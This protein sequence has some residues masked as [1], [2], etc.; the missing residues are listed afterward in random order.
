MG[1]REAE[2]QTD[3]EQ[4]GCRREH[5]FLF[6]FVFETESWAVTQAGV[7][8][9]DLG[10][11]QPP[12]LGSSDPPAS[13]SQNAGITDGS[14]CTR[15]IFFAR[16]VSQFSFCLLFQ[17][18]PAYSL[19]SAHFGLCISLAG[20]VGCKDVELSKGSADLGMTDLFMLRK[21]TAFRGKARTTNNETD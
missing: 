10:S 3:Q 4:E 11:L 13:A 17:M 12:P 16:H 15:P 19:S 5:L 7:Q 1:G 9:Y 14:H 21:K 6:C 2:G 18:A 8:W 20:Y